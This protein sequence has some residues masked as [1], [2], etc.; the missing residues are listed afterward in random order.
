LTVSE[1]LQRLE[2][3]IY[4]YS[5]AD[6]LAGVTRGTARRWLTGYGYSGTGGQRVSQPPVTG[7]APGADEGVSFVEL[8]ELVAIGGLKQLS[9]SLQEIR[10][11]VG[12]CQEL[13]GTR[14]PLASLKFKAGGR[15]IFVDRGEALVEVGRRKGAQA[16]NEVLEPFLRTLDYQEEL[17]VAVRWWPLGKETPI[18]VDPNYGF[19]FPVVAGS[20]VRTEVVFEQFQGGS[21]LKEIADDFRITDDEAERAVRFEATR[22]AA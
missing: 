10:T 3:P 6:H 19:G 15:D 16:W 22:L 7:A 4:S 5:E 8:V 12:N 18:L 17:G 20:G 9:F 11:I 2:Q 1:E 13:L 14:H 21:A